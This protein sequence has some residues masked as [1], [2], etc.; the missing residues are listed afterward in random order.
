[1]ARTP[2]IY[3]QRVGEWYPLYMDAANEAALREFATVT[4]DGPRTEPL[5]P[6]ELARTLAG[7]DGILSLNGLGA[8]EITTEALA[9]AGTVRVAAIAHWWHGGHVPATAMWRA[10]GVEVIDASDAT[11]E[12]VVEWVV[13]MAI[14]GVRRLVEFDHALKAGSPWAEPR[15]AAGLLGE[16]VVGLIGVGRVGRAAARQFRHFGATVI[17]YDPF[18]SEDE[19][20]ALGVRLASL[21]EVL[22]GADVISL[23]LAVTDA[24]RRMLG[25]RELALIKDGAVFINSARAALIDEAA[26]LA[27]LR[28]GRFRAYLDVFDVEPL[29][30]DSPWRMLD[31]VFIT[32]HVAGDTAAMFR[33]CGRLAIARL[34]EY[35]AAQTG[36]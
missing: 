5:A 23:H 4:S 22:G 21:D 35:F 19:G 12:A 33:R 7:V 3:I 17:G 31:N 27:E 15:R 8:A 10:A 14:V 18:L 25:A 28:K 20:R 34:R 24:T 26:F 30:L 36:Q 11:T 2:H 32:P 16:S 9:A 1:M 29:P 6:E 13:G